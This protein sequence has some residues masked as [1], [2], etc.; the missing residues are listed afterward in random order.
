MGCAMSC[1]TLRPTAMYVV[2]TKE[3]KKYKNWLVISRDVRGRYKDVLGQLGKC[4]QIRLE[5]AGQGPN[6]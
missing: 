3:R 6:K 1:Q 2:T 4:T 5:S